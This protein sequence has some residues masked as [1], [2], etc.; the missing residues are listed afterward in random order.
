MGS[1]VMLCSDTLSS[2]RGGTLLA[3][4]SWGVFCSDTLSFS[5][6]GTLLARASWAMLCSGTLSSSRGE[7][8]LARVSW[9][10]LCSGTLSSS[11]GGTLLARASWSLG[12]SSKG[13]MGV[14]GC[15][16]SASIG[17]ALGFLFVSAKEDASVAGTSS[18]SEEDAVCWAS[19]SMS[20]GVWGLCSSVLGRKRNDQKPFFCDFSAI[21]R[22]PLR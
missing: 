5:R 4:A 19:C 21:A 8:L 13:L 1:W 6:G 14:A 18:T 11:R 2:S 15:V 20:R 22:N 10:M 12:V 17:D 3:R 7:T 9:A 16:S